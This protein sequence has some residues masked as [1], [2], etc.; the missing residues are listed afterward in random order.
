MKEIILIKNGEIA[1]KGLNRSTFEDAMIKNIKRRM[2]HLGKVDAKKA[3][4]TVTIEPK[5]EFFDM[6]AAC[7]I[8]SKV[9]GV[10]AFCRACEIEK[11]MET[12]KK[13]A[14]EYLRDELSFAKT[15]K[16]VAKRSDKKFPL[17]SPE[18]CREVGGYLLSKFHNLSVDVIDPEVLVAVEV[19][20]KFAYI[21]T[22]QRDGAGGIPTGTGG[23]AMLLISGGIDSPVAG[24]MMAKRGIE[25]TAVH[26]A[27]PPYTSERALEKVKD[28]LRQMTHYTGRIKL[29]TVCFTKIQ[30]EIRDRVKEEYSTL[31]MRRFMMR[32]ANKIAEKNGSL[33]LITGESL[34]QVA[35]QTLPAIQC[36]DAVSALPTFRPL[37]GMDKE[38]IVAISRKIETFDISV[39]PF[40][41]CCTVFTPKH[42]KTK[43]NLAD[44]EKVE[45]VMDIEA[46][47]NEAVETVETEFVSAF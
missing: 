3:Q 31:V 33:A 26:F 20:D 6:D 41:D 25:L 37:I 1:L 12:I 46:L 11:D 24:Y 45:S 38:E 23:R 29:Y 40:E 30:E 8:V 17:T 4:S 16:V 22:N 14:A 44:F 15:F 2:A 9:F 28:L 5:D 10:S 43:P 7:D 39:Q 42:P 27:S 32:I 21:H 34:G 36:T 47:T 19:R 13:T 18:I 35:S